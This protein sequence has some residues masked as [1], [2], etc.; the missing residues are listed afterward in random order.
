MRG[1]VAGRSVVRTTLERLLRMTGWVEKLDAAA[2]SRGSLVCV[3]LD[4]DPRRMPVDDVA[5]FNRAI[6]DATRD[7]VCAYKPQ[8]AFYEALGLDGLRALEK[9]VSHIRDVAPDA[10]LVGDCKRGDIGST[11]AAY[12]RAM[13]DVWDFDTVTLHAYLGRDSVE[14]FLERADRGALIVCRTS[15]PGAVELQDLELTGGGAEGTLYEHTARLASEWNTRGNVGIVVGATYPG[16]MAALRAR[17][18]D[19]PFLVPGVGAQGGDVA[20]ASRAGVNADGRGVMISSSR[21]II[22]ASEDAATFAGAARRAAEPLRD[23]INEA[24]R[25]GATA[26]R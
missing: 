3:G 15:N 21:G 7:L 23:E 12:A 22:Y 16:E 11:A 24:L 13:F 19:M 25:S 20:A 1:R 26:A 18:P 10:V 5:E 17:H 9:T 6:I 2:R 4:P 14:P 8:L